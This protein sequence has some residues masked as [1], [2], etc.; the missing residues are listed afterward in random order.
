MVLFLFAVVG[1][2]VLV[3]GV[4]EVEYEDK[5]R[6][7]CRPEEV[8]KLPTARDGLRQCREC[9]VWNVANKDCMFC[10]E[11]REDDSVDAVEAR[12]PM[13]RAGW[14]P[15]GDG[16]WFMQVRGACKFPDIPA[17]K[18]TRR[19]SRH[20]DSGALFEDLWVT[21]STPGRLL[22]R[23][24]RGPKDLEVRVYVYLPKVAGALAWGDVELS[25]SDATAYRAAAARL[26]YMAQDRPDAM[27][28]AKECSRR[29]SRPTDKDWELVVRLVRYFIDKP[30]L[31]QT[32]EFGEAHM[33]I[34]TFCDSNWAGCRATRRS[35]SGACIMVGSHLIKAV[36]R[37]QAVV[38]LSSAEAELYSLVT[39]ASETLGVKALAADYGVDLGAWMWVDASAAIGIA[40]RKGLGKIRHIVTQAL[41]VQD[42]VQGKRLGL[43]KVLGHD[44]PSDLQTN[45]LDAAS[46]ARHL[47]RIGSQVRDGRPLA[48]PDH[49]SGQPGAG[50]G[51]VET[52]DVDEIGGK[53]CMDGVG[54]KEDTVEVKGYRAEKEE[55]RRVRSWWINRLAD[56]ERVELSDSHVYEEEVSLVEMDECLEKSW[57][58]HIS[59][60]DCWDGGAMTQTTPREPQ[61]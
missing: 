33:Y 58:A 31:V 35:T 49:V 56:E 10:G 38:A 60:T 17:G 9:S 11:G 54:G 47:R 30:R 52:E 40:R 21:P 5:T 19:V 32:Y 3:R 16:Q 8:V 55:L 44:N 25:P 15:A 23:E 51:E 42:A 20:L 2:R 57:M 28:A 12:C 34:D 59:A 36:S 24:F 4:V 22:Q 18:L 46:M 50:G 45:Y 41:W 7:H 53:H 48:A 1:C 6:Y 29:M 13:E 61:R 26:N 43:E 14:I 27:F 37:T 39:A